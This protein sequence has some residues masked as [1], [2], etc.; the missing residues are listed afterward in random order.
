MIK[1]FLVVVV[2]LMV[3]VNV[4]PAAAQEDALT[5]E[6]LALIEYLAGV[7]ETFF[8][9]KTVQ[10]TTVQ[11]IDQDVTAGTVTINQ[12]IHQ[13]M[14]TQIIYDEEGNLSALYSKNEQS[15][16][17]E[18]AGQ[19]AVTVDTDSEM[20][21]VDGQL[22]MRLT[23][24]QPGLPTGWFDPATL[25]GNI[26]NYDAMMEMAGRNSLALYPISPDTVVA[27]R[28]LEP[29]TVDGVEMRVFELEFATE[30]ILEQSGLEAMFNADAG[31]DVEDMVAKMG[32]DASYIQKI[33]IGAKDNMLYRAEF[34]L[35]TSMQD[36]E[37]TGAGAMDLVQ[38]ITGSVEYYGFNEPL[39]IEAPT[40][41]E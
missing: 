6:E 7:Y 26:Y 41:G 28:E 12:V 33:W 13:E 3:M 4:M 25:P 20:I 31:F 40:M 18:V 22:Y 19:P 27:I 32:D 15:L 23:T 5:E 8:T 21:M 10:A 37:V 38:D 29:E 14:Q 30:I 34:T 24:P 17:Q 9:L 1:R 36:I 2:V 35:Q 39:K 16:S 11:N